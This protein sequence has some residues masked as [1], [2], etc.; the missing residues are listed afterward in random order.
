LVKEL[1]ILDMLKST[2]IM[3]ALAF[4]VGGVLNLIL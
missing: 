4:F 1:G 2:A 3:V